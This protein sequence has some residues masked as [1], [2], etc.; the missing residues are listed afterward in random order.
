MSFCSKCGN[1]LP[2]GALFCGAC[3]NKIVGV[4]N[5]TSQPAQNQKMQQMPDYGQGQIPRY[6]PSYNPG[7][8]SNGKGFIITIISLL[9]V[10]ALA[11]GAYF[12]FWY[13]S[14]ESTSR[15][16]DGGDQSTFKKTIEKY[17]QAWI[18]GDAE[19]IMEATVPKS[20]WDDMED[21]SGESIEDAKRALMREWATDTDDYMERF[22]KNIKADVTI[23]K[24][25]K[26]DKDRIR[27]LEEIGK[28]I[29]KGFDITEAYEVEFEMT[30]KGS[31]GEETDTDTMEL[32]KIG[33]RWYALTAG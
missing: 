8:K 19:A 22:G 2:D 4:H 7:A 26:I 6:Y 13:D 27:E 9:I 16:S 23:I 33:S 20:M 5:Q 15:S 11:V 10:A 25:E 12:I 32:F 18:D 14:G 3:G 21:N 17:A 31:E 24:K 28:E 1:Q 29:D 30:I